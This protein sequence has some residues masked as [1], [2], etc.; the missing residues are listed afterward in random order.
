VNIK[1]N[2]GSGYDL[3]PLW[4]LTTGQLTGYLEEM[5][6]L[7]WELGVPLYATVNF[8]QFLDEEEMS[9]RGH[10]H[11]MRYSNVEST[12]TAISAMSRYYDY[13]NS[14]ARR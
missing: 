3:S 8:H 14:N 12:C 10:P 5:Y 1:E 6:E 7:M 9:S 11:V 2:G 4:N 13:R